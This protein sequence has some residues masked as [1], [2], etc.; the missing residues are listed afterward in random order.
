MTDTEKRAHDIALAYLQRA[1]K[2]KI[3]SAENCRASM[4]AYLAAYNYACEQLEKEKLREVGAVKKYEIKD[5][6]PHV[7][8]GGVTVPLH[9]VQKLSD[10]QHYKR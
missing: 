5:D 1:W 2:D 7:N 6:E 3:F 4:Q 9:I 8:I 10:K